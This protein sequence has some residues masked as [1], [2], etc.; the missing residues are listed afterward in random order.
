MIYQFSFIS[1]YL[2]RACFFFSSPACDN[3]LVSP[4]SSLRLFN[5]RPGSD[6]CWK[7]SHWF[8]S[9]VLSI[10]PVLP[11]V[12]SFAAICRRVSVP[13]KRRSASF[14][15][16]RR[17]ATRRSRRCR[18]STKLRRSGR[19]CWTSWPSSTRRSMTRTASR[20]LPQRRNT[21]QKWRACRMRLQRWRLV[22]FSFFH[23]FPFLVMFTY[24]Q[25]RSLL[26]VCVC[27]CVCVCIGLCMC[28][29]AYRCGCA[30][31]WV[32]VCVRVCVCM[33]SHL[34]MCEHACV[35][36]CVCVCAHVC[37]YV[38]VAK[39]SAL[40]F[41][42]E[43]WV[44]CKSILLSWSSSSSSK[45]KCICVCVCVCSRVAF[46]SS[47]RPSRWWKRCRPKSAP[48]RTPRGGW[49]AGWKRRRYPVLQNGTLL[50]RSHHPPFR[51]PFLKCSLRMF[52]QMNHWS[53][54][55]PLLLRQH[56]WNLSLH[57]FLVSEHIYKHNPPPPPPP[58][59][60]IF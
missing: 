20:A 21:R 28:L 30:C 38:C 19:H 39:C 26:R 53:H 7:L 57:Y 27:V 45:W 8:S 55:S 56:F 16:P 14:R 5:T 44:L 52:F 37:T 31:L 32:C 43:D 11:P 49:N 9:V 17:S 34:N 54:K 40:P 58:A 36:V 46:S 22:V 10:C 50:E 3:I 12:Y 6:M 35:C 42:E 18:K 41:H 59:T 4:F 24:L 25:G 51:P 13:V 15:L 23:F 33:R 60:P 2:N 1:N 48:W 29:C 47:A